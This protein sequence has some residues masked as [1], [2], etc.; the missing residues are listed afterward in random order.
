MRVSAM[1]VFKL[2]GLRNLNNYRARGRAA[3]DAPS[4]RMPIYFTGNQ[5]QCDV[6]T[7]KWAAP[8]KLARQTFHTELSY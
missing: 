4:M 1:C 6:D 2:M 5:F 7:D 3:I 8:V